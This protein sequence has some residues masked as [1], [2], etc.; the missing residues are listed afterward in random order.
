MLYNVYRKKFTS[1]RTGKTTY[2][3]SVLTSEPKDNDY[4][5]FEKVGEVNR[6]DSEGRVALQ[7]RVK[8]EFGDPTP[9]GEFSEGMLNILSTI[10]ENNSDYSK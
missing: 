5:K 10:M 7:I 3:W 2:R 8:K 4:T 9:T 1:Q 6:E